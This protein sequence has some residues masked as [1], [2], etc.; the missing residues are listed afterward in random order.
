MILVVELMTTANDAAQFLHAP[1][2]HGLVEG[3]EEEEGT[4]SIVYELHEASVHHLVAQGMVTQERYLVAVELC[5]GLSRQLS[6]DRLVDGVY[7]H[8]DKLIHPCLG[9]GY[10]LR[11]FHLNFYHND[12]KLGK[13]NEN[14][15]L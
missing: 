2:T 7:K 8:L 13:K 1:G 3:I 4:P 15:S 12:A 10:Q 11:L 5:H 9:C 14:D 6:A